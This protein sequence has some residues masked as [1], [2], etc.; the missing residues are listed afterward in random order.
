[1]KSEVNSYGLSIKL[2]DGTLGNY[3]IKN[4]A[5]GL[6]IRGT[7]KYFATMSG[8]VD[9]YSHKKRPALGIQLVENEDLREGHM[10]EDLNE[11]EDDD[12]FTSVSLLPFLYLNDRPCSNPAS[13]SHHKHH[14]PAC[15]HQ[16]QHKVDRGWRGK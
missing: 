5:N 4:G 3:L 7:Q 15:P 8:L 6:V 1:V 2:R 12:D 10:D 13:P 9:Y 14:R 11:N 16:H